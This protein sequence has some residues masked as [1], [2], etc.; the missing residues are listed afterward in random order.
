MNSR[1]VVSIVGIV[2][3]QG[4]LVCGTGFAATRTASFSVSVTVEAGCQI[5]PAGSATEGA[6]SG[7]KW[8]NSPVS[9]NCSLPVPYQVTVDS[10]PQA[11]L[12]RPGATI[13][14]L[15]GLPRY[16]HADD[17]DL[18]PPH[19]P[20]ITPL[21]HSDYDQVRPASFG[22]TAALPEA[23]LCSADDAAPGTITVTI[24]Y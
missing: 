11:T 16:A 8:G 20:S 13:P 6:A 1:S 15:A 3:L 22:L 24:V 23:A 9:V 7:S 12:A 14:G 19:D 5:S 4:G 2:A 21:E 18:L 17:R 10:I